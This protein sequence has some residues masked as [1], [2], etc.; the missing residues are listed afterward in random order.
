LIFLRVGPK[1]EITPLIN[2][3]L[4]FAWARELIIIPP[5]LQISALFKTS[6]PM[7]EELKPFLRL[8]LQTSISVSLDY[9]E[10]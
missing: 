7:P 6:A 8:P 3:R 1:F 2:Q 10:R 9:A 4:F 5:I